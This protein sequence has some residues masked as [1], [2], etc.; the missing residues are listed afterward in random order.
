MDLIF[1]SINHQ[2]CPFL[3]MECFNGV[4]S[5]LQ[6]TTFAGLFRS[7]FQLEFGVLFSCF[8]LELCVS[9]HSIQEILSAL[10][11]A[12]ML[13]A[14]VD[15]LLHNS[16]ANKFVQFNSN[17][18]GCDVPHNTSLAMVEFVGHSLVDRT[19]SNNVN[20]ISAM[21]RFKESLCGE[22]SMFAKGAGKHVAGASAITE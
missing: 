21:V 19:N 18:S 22:S 3:G 4:L 1:L 12:D 8:L 14:N 10:G 15:S 13:D 5:Q 2:S 9:F 7:S 17:G 11:V 20:N 16:V 6:E